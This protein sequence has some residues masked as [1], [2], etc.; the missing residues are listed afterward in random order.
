MRVD[1]K[2]SQMAMKKDFSREMHLNRELKRYSDRVLYW[3][4]NR[5][6]TDQQ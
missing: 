5:N 2:M 6:S 3:T 4:V 1:R